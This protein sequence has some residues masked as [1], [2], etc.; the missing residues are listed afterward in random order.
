VAERVV[1]AL[2]ARGYKADL[3]EEYDNRLP[4]YLADALVSI[5]ADSCDIAKAS[6]FKVARVSDSAIPEAEDALVE[7]LYAQYGRVTGLPRHDHS[8]T[9]DMH[10]YHVFLEIDPQTP[11]AIIEIGFLGAD[12]DTLENHPERAA[13]GIFA[14]LV[15]FLEC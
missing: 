2:R 10:G 12:R 3:L 9:P 13:E 8:I 7:C 14:G 4:G 5:H 1:T 15:C 6:G 11:G